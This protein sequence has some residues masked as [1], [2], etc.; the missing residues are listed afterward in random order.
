MYQIH[1]ACNGS[2][3]RFKIRKYMEYMK[4]LKKGFL[5]IDYQ[6]MEYSVVRK[7]QDLFYLPGKYILKYVENSVTLCERIANS[8]LFS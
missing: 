8:Y 2:T 4:R 7:S 3:I 6:I 1:A 5:N